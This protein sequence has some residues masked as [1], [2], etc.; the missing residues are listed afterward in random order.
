MA[1]GKGSNRVSIVEMAPR[2]GLQNE[3]ALIDTKDKIRLVD[4]LSGCGF[5]RIEVTSFVSPKWVP[6]LADAAEVMAGISR[7]DGVHYAVLTPNLK[8]FEAA[9]T[10]GADEVA[11]FASASESFSWHNINC[12][13]DESVERFRPVAEAAAAQGI[14]MRGYVSCVVECP[15]EGAIE[16]ASTASVADR[17]LALGCFEI[18]LGDT[19]GRGRPEAID[20]MLARVLDTIP[21]DRLAGHFHDTA[22]RA[23]ENIGVALKRGIRVFDASVGGLGGCP[24]APGAK[25]N[26]DTLAVDRYL[27]ALGFETGLSQQALEEASAFAR[28]LRSTP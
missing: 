20:A 17:L 15:Y 28:S 14:P 18:S 22:G 26:V 4:M 7:R 9:L 10:A 13:I 27:T 12:S 1:V 2:D 19:I 8:G 6:Q 16:P 3:A 21:A 24:Y 5:D 25:G 11:I 23:L